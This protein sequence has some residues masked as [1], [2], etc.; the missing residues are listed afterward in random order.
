MAMR[1]A[2]RRTG[3][4]NDKAASDGINHTKR[5]IYDQY[6][7]VK[8]QTPSNDASLQRAVDHR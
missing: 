3:R 5:T 1:K 4:H 2:M 6:F 8:S 7:E